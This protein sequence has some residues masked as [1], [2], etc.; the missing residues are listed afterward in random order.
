M[1]YTTINKSTD[2]FNT[3]LYTGDGTTSKAITGVGHQPDLVWIKDR[4]QSSN[5][6]LQDAVRGKSGSNYYYIHSDSN[7]AQSVQTDDDGVNTLGADG[8]TVGYTNSTAWNENN[9]DYVSWN[10]KANGS[11]SSNTD[12]SITSTVSVNTTSKMSIVKFTGTGSVATVGHGL[13]SV[14]KMILFKNTTRASNWIVYHHSLGNTKNLYLD[15]TNAEHDRADTFND[16]SPTSSVFT[17]GT[18]DL[19]IDT[20]TIIAYCF[21]EV[22]GFSKFS[23]YIGNGDA[24][25]SPFIYLGFKPKFVII[26]N[27]GAA[28]EW[29][30]FDNKRIGYNTEGNEKLYPDLPN[31]EADISEIDLVSNGFKLR[32]GGN[33]ANQDGNTMVYMAFGQTIVGTNNTPATAR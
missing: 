25:N 5:H 31:A 23:S 16:T 9:T 21:A 20:E 32:T 33:Q 1:A 22:D 24:T 14:P 12:G 8:F 7:A 18:A 11:G 4:D 19:N 3:V 15:D 6:Q 27:S 10:W 29:V 26:K 28:Q 30:M 17:V 2:F 13:G